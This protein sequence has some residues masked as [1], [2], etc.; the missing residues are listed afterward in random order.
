MESRIGPIQEHAPTVTALMPV[1]NA[2]AYLDEAIAS[3]TGQTFDDFEFLIVNDHSTDGG[4]AI[5][6]KHAGR[7]SRIRL[8]NNRKTKGGGRRL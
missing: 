8:L 2:E 3:I 5:I 7:D 1:Y 4:E 6:R